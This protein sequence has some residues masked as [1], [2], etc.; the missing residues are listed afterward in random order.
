MR[1]D[2]PPRVVRQILTKKERIIASTRRHWA[3]LVEPVAS[4]LAGTVF[5]AWFG[6]SF[7][8]TGPL[9]NLVWL[10]WLVLLGRTCWYW[11]LWW[12]HCFVVTNERIMLVTGGLT[13]TTTQLPLVFG[14]DITLSQHL[15]GQWLGF[16]DFELETAPKDHPLGHKITWIPDCERLHR[17]I[18][19]QIQGD[20]ADGHDSHQHTNDTDMM[21]PAYGEDGGVVIIDESSRSAPE[22]VERVHRQAGESAP[23]VLQRGP[24]LLSLW[25]G[26][27]STRPSAPAAIAKRSRFS[28]K[29]KTVVP[30]PGRIN[31]TTTGKDPQPHRVIRKL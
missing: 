4:L 14:K 24:G 10:G 2:R 26:I 11:F 3:W 31:V 20:T 1:H 21:V 17:R 8:D 6:L 28:R 27:G 29:P 25:R 9:I 19:R 18:S 5:A 16:G 15:I 22:K 30:E 13:Q 23:V 7:S 12:R